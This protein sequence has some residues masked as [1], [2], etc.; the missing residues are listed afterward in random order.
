MSKLY[1]LINTYELNK[2]FDD[3]ITSLRIEIFE[4]VSNSQYKQA[5][6]WGIR[7]YDLYPTFVN[8]VNNVDK[9]IH[10]SDLLSINITNLVIDDLTIV[11]GKKIDENELL[12][13]V[14]ESINKTIDVLSK[15]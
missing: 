9:P 5:R 14:I 10:S 6:V 7:S 4:N 15:L 8:L 11:E 3:N 1:K 13:N 2:K 12:E